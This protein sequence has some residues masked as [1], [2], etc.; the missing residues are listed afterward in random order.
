MLS[1]LKLRICVVALF[2]ILFYDVESQEKLFDSDSVLKIDI[3]TDLKKLF[4]DVNPDKA[5]YHQ[6]LITYIDKNGSVVKIDAKFKTRGIFRRSKEN[7]N[8]PPIS[9]KFCEDDVN[10]TIFKEID[11]IKLVNSCNRR[12]DVFKQYLV[13]EYL[14]YKLYNLLTNYSF[15]VRLVYISYIDINN[16]IS[17][18]ESLG[19]FIED[20][21]SLNGRTKSSNVK[22]LGITQEA[23]DWRK[24]D[25][26]AVFQYM[27]G[28]TDWSVPKLH[29]IKL[30]VGSSSYTPIAIPY[31]F[32]FCG[33]VNPPYT[34][35]PDIIPIRHVTIRYYRGFCRTIDELMPILQVFHDNK[36]SIYRVISTDTLLNEKH[37][38]AIL[39]YIDEFYFTLSNNKLIEREFIDNC[40]TE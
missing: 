3:V 6:G 36:E 29:N 27:I 14:A 15:K 4:R 20:M 39:M 18:F 19:F 8:L 25:V 13:K 22:T 32:D 28:N 23:V 16:S 2:S 37:K 34:K 10:N 21:K 35:P 30:V 1:I 7:C 17:P 26:T 9:I 38:K 31:D 33:F 5:T 12:R 11:K 40:R 24:M